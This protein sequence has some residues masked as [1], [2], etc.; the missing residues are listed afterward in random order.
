MLKTLDE[1]KA[2]IEG[3][4]AERPTCSLCW[5]R[6]IHRV[7]SFDEMRKTGAELDVLRGVV[8]VRCETCATTPMYP[9]AARLDAERV[10]AWAKGYEGEDGAVINW[11]EL[12]ALV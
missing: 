6:P 2:L 11:D 8:I 4:V 3:L 12:Q 7:T 5:L 9:W 1:A 10:L